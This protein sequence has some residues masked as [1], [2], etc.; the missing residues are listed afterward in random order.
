MS[1]ESERLGAALADR[2]HI[3]RV[4][5]RGGMATVYLADDVRHRRKVAIKVLSSDLAAALGA[6]RFL[7][8]IQ[9]TANLQHPHILPLHD[10]GV[11]DGLLFYVMPFVVG[12]SLR[13]RMNRE[14][15]MEVGAALAIAEEVA[16]ALS[17][18]HRQ[19]VVHRDVK[20]ENVLLSEGHA[21]VTDF[22]IAK[23]V[24]SASDEPLTRTGFALGT[25]GYMSPEQAAGGQSVTAL[26]DVYSLACVIYEMLVGTVPSRWISEDERREEHF[27]KAPPAH[28]ARFG[29]LSG[30]VERALVRGMAIDPEHRFRTPSELVRALTAPMPPAPARHYSETEAKEIL[31]HAASL[32]ASEPTSGHEFSLTGV[33]RMAGEVDIPSRHV[34]AA[35]SALEAPTTRVPRVLGVPAGMELR[36]TVGGQVAESEYPVL[37]EIIQDTLGEPGEIESALG[38]VFAWTTG[39]GQSARLSGRLTR[40]QV[41]PRAGSTR[42]TITEDQTA[43]IAVSAG[44]GSVVIGGLALPLAT[45]SVWA[46]MAPVAG[47]VVAAVAAFRALRKRRR[48]QLSELLERLTHHVSTSTGVKMLEGRDSP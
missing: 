42:I 43:A 37:L 48:A 19:G 3:E 5:G 28:K 34:A 40:V 36:R 14:G 30:S 21:L 27:L 29:E 4:V 35:A 11:A 16:D 26:T 31:K 39:R 47:L 1:G 6:D 8:E 18:A 45:A 38:S 25:P 7:H 46:M 17:Y 33:K 32:E 12:E 2:Y 22:G 20:P 10:S 13:H 9:V 24:T 15:A 23:A 44:V 41:S